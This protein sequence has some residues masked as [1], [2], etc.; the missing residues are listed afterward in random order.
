[1]QTAA[2]VLAPADFCSICLAG[3]VSVSH[4]LVI[5]DGYSLTCLLT[6]PPPPLLFSLCL[7]LRPIIQAGCQDQA[8][9]AALLQGSEGGRG[10]WEQHSEG[11]SLTG[12]TPTTIC[13]CTAAI[14]PLND[15]LPERSGAARGPWHSLLL[16]AS[17]QIRLPLLPLKPHLQLQP[18]FKCQ[19]NVRSLQV[20]LITPLLHPCPPGSRRG[21]PRPRSP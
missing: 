9:A 12:S 15:T 7:F 10:A 4:A 13:P 17:L 14:L 6:P 5:S 18:R 3:F 11:S 19:I 1:M 20:L 8:A 16:T 2:L 21:C